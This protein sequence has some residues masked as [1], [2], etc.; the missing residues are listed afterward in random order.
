MLCMTDNG[1]GSPQNGMHHAPFRTPSLAHRQDPFY[2]VS[3]VRRRQLPF[4]HLR[5]AS[6]EGSA[7]SIMYCRL[8]DI[9]CGR[10]PWGYFWIDLANRPWRRPLPYRTGSQPRWARLLQE[11]MGRQRLTVRAYRAIMVTCCAW[12][13]EWPQKI[14]STSTPRENDYALFRTACMTAEVRP[15]WMT[16]DRDWQYEHTAQDWPHTVRDRMN[17][18]RRAS[19]SS[20]TGTGPWWKAMAARHSSELWLDD[21]TFP[22]APSLTLE[23]DFAGGDRTWFLTRVASRPSLHEGELFKPTTALVSALPHSLSC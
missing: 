9:V 2:E 18:R 6:G 15:D 12:P 7:Q 10:S 19:T 14:D 22:S 23:Y 21:T 17:D 8:R 11:K 4:V 3:L 16:A 1:N 20:T 5:V 13:H